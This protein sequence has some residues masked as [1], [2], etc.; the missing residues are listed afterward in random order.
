MKQ[1]ISLQVFKRLYSTN[2]TWSLLVYYVPRVTINCKSQQ[3]TTKDCK[4]LKNWYLVFNL[5][6]S[7]VLILNKSSLKHIL[8]KETFE[9]SF[10]KRLKCA[11]AKSYSWRTSSTSFL[12]SLCTALSLKYLIEWKKDINNSPW[13]IHICDR[14]T[15]N[16]KIIIIII[17]T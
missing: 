10:Q 15:K 16:N 6:Y 13:A 1:T 17:H 2:L 5:F 7:E 4:W 9:I 14:L 12:F 3:V 11:F 8:P